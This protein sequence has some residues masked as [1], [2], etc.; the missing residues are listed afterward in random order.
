VGQCVR[1]PSYGIVIAAE[2]EDHDRKF[3]ASFPDYGVKKLVERYACLNSLEAIASSS[4][5]PGKAKCRDEV[6][7]IPAWYCT[8][9]AVR[10]SDAT[11]RARARANYS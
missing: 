8:A 6:S 2:G 10:C 7:S 1:H 3:T 4:A 11:K 9:T 5:A